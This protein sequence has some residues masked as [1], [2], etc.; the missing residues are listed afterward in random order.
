[1]RLV[2]VPVPIEPNFTLVGVDETTHPDDDLL[3]Q[4]QS[5]GLAPIVID[6][7]TVFPDVV[8]LHPGDA[9]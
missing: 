1:V 2:P 7:N 4:L 8:A 9:S 3:A 5:V 6:E